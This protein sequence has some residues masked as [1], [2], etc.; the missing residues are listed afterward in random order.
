MVNCFLRLFIQDL[1][2]SLGL[3]NLTMS[4]GKQTNPEEKSIKNQNNHFCRHTL[5][6]GFMRK[7]QFTFQSQLPVSV[8]EAFTWYLRNGA[9]ERLLPPW[10]KIA[11]L[12]P[13]GSPEEVGS[14]IG[15]QLKWGPF[16]C[17]W[18]LEHR[19]YSVDQEFSTV[20]TQGP[21]G[22]YLHRHKFTPIDPIS[23][24]LSDEITYTFSLPLLHTKIQKHFSHLF[25]WQHSIL[26]EDLKIIDNY[27]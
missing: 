14:R 2:V 8:E 10:S 1:F 7:R 5:K 22:D 13:P 27:Q 6:R 11:I 20:Q 15:L 17:K 18:I 3:V 23:C 12:F 9:I 26:R 25:S 24:K 4:Y 19:H 16:R 21:F